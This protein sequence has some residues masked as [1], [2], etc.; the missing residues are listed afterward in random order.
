MHTRW[1]DG[2]GTVHD[3]AEAAMQ[4]GYEYIAITEHSKGLRVANGIDERTLAEQ[5]H[6]VDALNEQLSA[7]HSPLTV[8]HSIEMNLSPSGAGDMD[9]SALKKLDLVLGSFHSA[10]QR[11]EDQTERYLAALGNPHV[12][13]LDHPRGRIYNYRLGLRADWPRVFDEAARLDKA[14]EIDAYPDRQDLNLDLLQIARRS[15]ARIHSAPIRITL[16]A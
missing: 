9:A 16:A 8:L 1:S 5:G 6:E 14:V 13:I 3:M 2:S 11:K 4:R 15:G 10:L 7:R 12:H